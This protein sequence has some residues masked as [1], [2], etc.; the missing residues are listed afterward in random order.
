MQKKRS[1][2][3]KMVKESESSI[4]E[5]ESKL[6]EL[7]RQLQD[8]ENASN[9]EMVEQYSQLQKKLDAEMHKWEQWST[10]LDKIII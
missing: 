2:L 5:L 6:E 10:E 1:K 4:S 7:D 3:E 9:M 8:V